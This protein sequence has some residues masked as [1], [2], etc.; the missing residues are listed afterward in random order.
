VV[1][2]GSGRE[3]LA[4]GFRPRDGDQTGQPAIYWRG[5]AR[6]GAIAVWVQRL[7]DLDSRIGALDLEWWS[8]WPSEPWVHEAS[9]VHRLAAQITHGPPVRRTIDVGLAV[10][11]RDRQTDTPRYYLWGDYAPL[12]EQSVGRETEVGVRFELEILSRPVLWTLITSLVSETVSGLPIDQSKFE[13]AR[14]GPTR[15]TVAIRSL[16]MALATGNLYDGATHN[17]YEELS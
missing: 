9:S 5:A 8:Q 4:R 1:L 3:H 11:A 12:G 2:T 6:A 17:R 10:T 14:D 7:V 16:L 15:T 13:P